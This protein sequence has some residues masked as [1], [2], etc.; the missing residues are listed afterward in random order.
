MKAPIYTITND[1]ITIIWKGELV[2]VRQAMPNFKPLRAAIMNEAWDE[3]ADHISSSSTVKK[4]VHGF[5]SVEGGNI[6]FKNK[7]LPEEL[8]KRIIAMAAEGKDPSAIFNFWQKLQNNPSYRSVEQL[9]KFLEHQGIPLVANGNFLAYKSV[10]RTFMDH[11][12]G[13]ICNAPGMTVE[14][15]RNQISDDPNTPCHEGL[16]VGALE[17]AENFRSSDIAKIVICEIDPAD[18]VCVPHD[19]SSMKMRVCRYTVIGVHNDGKMNNV[20]MDDE[21]IAGVDDD[22]RSVSYDASS[23]DEIEFVSSIADKSST[24]K[25][26]AVPPGATDTKVLRRYD[27]YPYEKLLDQR[28]ED[29]RRYASKCLSIVG[30]HHVPGGKVGLVNLI[31]K[32]R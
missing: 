14:M 31:I 10:S 24:K 18:V 4:W 25:L 12:T 15:P 20:F 23:E 8:E 27:D 30:A 29:L 28:L 26:R 19:Y 11:H 13:T 5:F 3:I 9:W 17:Y 22:D 7:K 21:D 16:H 32:M 2:T 6:Y 1:M